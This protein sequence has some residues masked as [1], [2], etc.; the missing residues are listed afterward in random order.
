MQLLVIF[1]LS[2]IAKAERDIF[3]AFDE[4]KKNDTISEAALI[5]LLTSNVHQ[6]MRGKNRR[7]SS[8]HPHTECEEPNPDSDIQDSECH[9]SRFTILTGVV[10]KYSNTWGVSDTVQDTLN[11]LYGTSNKA[12]KTANWLVG[13]LTG[14]EGLIHGAQ[15]LSQGLLKLEDGFVKSGDSLWSNLFDIANVTANDTALLRSASTQAISDLVNNTQGQLNQEAKAHASII[16]QVLKYGNDRL[17]LVQGAINKQQSQLET[18]LSEFKSTSAASASSLAASLDTTAQVSDDTATF[19]EGVDDALKSSARQEISALGDKLTSMSAEFNTSADSQLSIL[20]KSLVGKEAVFEASSQTL[21]AGSAANLSADVATVEKDLAEKYAG[22]M[23]KVDDVKEKLDGLFTAA[24][25]Q[26][27]SEV[28]AMTDRGQTT[29]EGLTFQIK[30]VGE[31]FEVQ[32]KTLSSF[33]STVST[34]LSAFET[35]AKSDALAVSKQLSSL[36]SGLS[37][38]SAQKLLQLVMA[39]Q[40]GDGDLRNSQQSVQAELYETIQQLASSLGYTTQSA[41]TAVTDATQSVAAMADSASSKTTQASSSVGSVLR[42]ASTEVLQ[43]IMSQAVS[44]S[45]RSLDLRSSRDA[46]QKWLLSNLSKNSSAWKSSFS[47]SEQQISSK[48]ETLR[49]ASVEAE[50]QLYSSTK[51]VSAVGQEVFAGLS[52]GLKY[53]QWLGDHSNSLT[54]NQKSLLAALAEKLA[55]TD[56]EAADKIEGVG[57]DALD[58]IRYLLSSTAKGDSTQKTRLTSQAVTSLKTEEAASEVLGLKAAS[59]DKS[60]AASLNLSRSE[61][62]SVSTQL[63]FTFASEQKESENLHYA[64]FSPALT[65]AQGVAAALLAHANARVTAEQSAAQEALQKQLLSVMTLFNAE[66]HAAAEKR[67]AEASDSRLDLGKLKVKVLDAVNA[68]NLAAEKYRA[69]FEANGPEKVKSL[70]RQVSDSAANFDATMHQL[71]MNLSFL[72]VSSSGYLVNLTTDLNATIKSLPV[73]AL[74]LAKRLVQNIFSRDASAGI[75][76]LNSSAGINL[77]GAQI[78]KALSSAA[79][80][81]ASDSD[82]LE[83]SISAAIRENLAATLYFANGPLKHLA[84]SA[85]IRDIALKQNVS[86]L[87]QISNGI[88]QRAAAA[89]TAANGTVRAALSDWAAQ[90]SSANQTANFNMTMASA[91]ASKM[92]KFA[93]TIENSSLQGVEDLSDLWTGAARAAQENATL[94]KMTV[95]AAQAAAQQRLGAVMAALSALGSGMAAAVDSDISGLEINLALTRRLLGELINLW[96]DYAS[97]DISKF[98]VMKEQTMQYLGILDNQVI[99]ASHELTDKLN[100]AIDSAA[101]AINAVDSSFNEEVVF[102]TGLNNSLASLNGSVS[103]NL[104]S[105]AAEVD[106]VASQVQGL[107]AT[108]AADDE[109]FTNS[110]ISMIRKFDESLNSRLNATAAILS[111]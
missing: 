24:N 27:K 73:L 49:T 77:I 38:S 59:L 98:E 35:S 46:L 31:S 66:A 88:L 106:D 14:P 9:A 44:L 23:S 50:R 18:A 47:E 17:D 10:E 64:E 19:V 89:A 8:P 75:D 81:A 109:A 69:D 13:N 51:K 74:V 30:N 97:A 95:V 80:S 90:L 70:S 34:E 28:D 1:S 99:L 56:S 78:S 39:L 91:Q 11:Q 96:S 41:A 29:A 15:A 21:L 84:S 16:K 103:A 107:N 4:M 86:G 83:K 43:S 108:D 32:K 82:K 85:R 92:M 33:S 53:V 63:A 37:G 57:K 105:V 45:G 100:A 94:A 104:E 12:N 111:R 7:R 101:A 42:G 55:S 5:E 36:L 87:S 102:E 65:N 60:I 6:A 68:T 72:N 2:V 110:A 67:I 40:S 25:A 76:S 26:E 71:N 79:F 3:K 93:K 20:S 58:L 61:I 54:G 62:K 48:A 22:L 52:D